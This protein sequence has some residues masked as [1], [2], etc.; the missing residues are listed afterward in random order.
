ML[1]YTGKNEK[2]FVDARC[3]VTNYNEKTA[4]T[5]LITDYVYYI[6]KTFGLMFAPEKNSFNYG[7]LSWAVDQF[8]CCRRTPIKMPRPYIEGNQLVSR[9]NFTE[10]SIMEA[11][12]AFPGINNNNKVKYNLGI[13]SKAYERNFDSRYI[14]LNPSDRAGNNSYVLSFENINSDL[15]KDYEKFISN[16]N[17]RN[18]KMIHD[19]IK[20]YKEDVP[21]GPSICKEGMT[22]EE[23]FLAHLDSAGA[24]FNKGL[25]EY[26]EENG[27]PCYK[28]TYKCSLDFEKD[29]RKAYGE[30]RVGRYF[31]VILKN[32]DNAANIMMYYKY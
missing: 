11:Y 22:V 2:A 27:I 13:R 19:M 21:N 30:D 20:K 31:D 10:K 29:I 1:K 8:T 24:F 26:C 14:A 32:K 5:F 9:L 3:L 15:E 17:M 7:T 23:Q 28:D 25:H 6:R 16:A 4:N 12:I 18:W